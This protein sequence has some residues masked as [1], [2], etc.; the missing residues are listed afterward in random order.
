MKNALLPIILLFTVNLF[1]QDL[2]KHRWQNR[3]LIIVD[4]EV[5]SAN[6]LAQL[7][8]LKA[9]IKGLKERKLLVYQFTKNGYQKGFSNQDSWLAI[10][11]KM[12]RIN[13]EKSAF[14]LYLIGLDGGVKMEKEGVVTL[15][16]IFTLIDGMPM[17]R[18]EMQDNW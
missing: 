16:S 10:T 11:E 1:A 18:A 9:D 8:V 17:R 6:R 5:N 13:P 12:T 3:L 7:A 2:Q 4:N 14:T 15:T